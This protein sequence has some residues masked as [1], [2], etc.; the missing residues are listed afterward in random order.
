MRREWLICLLLAAIT[1]TVY[2]P[3][4]N[5]DFVDYD[6]PQFI[7]QNPVIREGLTRSSVHYALTTSVLANWHPVTTLSHIL[8]CQFFGLRPGAHHLISAVFHAANA[9]LLFLLLQRLTG[10]FWRSAIVAAVFALHPL[11]VESVAWIA[12]RKDVLSALFFLLTL[13]TYA[14]YVRENHRAPSQQDQSTRF[15]PRLMFRASRY[16]VLSLFLFALGLMSKPMLV[17]LPF[18]LLLLDVWP[19]NRFDLKTKDPELK[20][21][22]P[23]VWEK[24]PFFILSAI[25]CCV[26][27]VTQQEATEINAGI[28]I[29]HRIANG[30]ISY[31]RYLGKFFWPAKLTVLYPHPIS[32]YEPIQVV[33]AALALIA[34]SLGCI[35]Q[36]RSR[37]YLAIGWFW[38]LGTLVPVIGLVQVGGQAMADRYTY[39]PLIGPVISLVWLLSDLSAQL[40]L[41][42][43]VR[44]A[45]AMTITVFVLLCL[46]FLTRQQLGV[47]QNTVTLFAHALEVIPDNPRA[48]VSL[49]VGLEKRGEIAKAVAH[50]QRAL[51]LQ[52]SYH[53]AHYNLGQILRKNGSWAEA[54]EHY[55]V[56][57]ESKPDDVAVHANLANVLQNLGRE[58]EAIAHFEETL[59]LAPNLVEALNN[60]AWLLA[61][62]AHAESRNGPR[63]VELAQ[64]ACEL[65]G[66]NETLLVGTLAAAYAE[67]GRFPE[68]VATAE[69]ASALASD[70]GQK[71]LLK[72]NQYLLELYRSQKPYHETP[73]EGTSGKSRE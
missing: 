4:R 38:F 54:A 50:Y 5:H 69:K 41:G 12:E 37:P 11:R 33:L 43:A 70:L 18:V 57:L 56:V 32:S 36:L 17:T 14:R 68:A 24:I 39:I 71:D 23:L 47:W 1:L 67:A 60:L 42:D 19:L 51:A 26:T 7:T 34:V 28:P 61:S 20:S 30:F 3:V 49:G 2:W 25:F 72:K 63:A 58:E 35:W 62:S 45:A 16:Y 31:L 8:D 15:P 21:L 40:G 10:A 6:D 52:P 65:T 73:N 44:A 27:L 22:L 55:Y 13:L 66:F 59:R 48:E 53:V 29:E 46:E 64:R 9:V